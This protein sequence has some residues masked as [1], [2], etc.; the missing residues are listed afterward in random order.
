MSL[1]GLIIGLVIIGFVLYLIQMLPID[2]TIKKIIYAVVILVV[3][4][5]VLQG[6]GGISGVGNLNKP[7]L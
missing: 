6:L 2:G 5:W 1:I 4:I 3:I 7:I